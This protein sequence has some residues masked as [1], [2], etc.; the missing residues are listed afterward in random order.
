MCDTNPYVTVVTVNYNNDYGLKRT[1][2]SLAYLNVKPARVII[3]DA[4]SSDDSIEIANLFKSQLNLDIH[5]EPDDGIYFGMNKGKQLV[6]TS[7]I[8]YLNSGDEVYGEPYQDVKTEVCL[9][10]TLRNENGRRI[11]LDKLKLFGYGYNHQGIIFSSN[12]VDYDCNYLIASDSDLIVKHFPSGLNA[13]PM[14]KTGGVNYYLDGFSTKNMREGNLEI[15]KTFY[16]NNFTVFP[17]VFSYILLK[18]FLP[19][20]VRRILFRLI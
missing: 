2:S 15:L 18:S 20:K 1:L 10:V 14:F 11:G 9:E 19:R 6:N 13:L 4:N 16:R 3:I 8:H 12:H 7:L 5:S 17:K